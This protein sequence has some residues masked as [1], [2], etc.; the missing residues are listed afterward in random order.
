M[1]SFDPIRS[2]E[3]TVSRPRAPLAA[4]GAFLICG[5]MAGGCGD[6]SADADGSIAQADASIADADGSIAQADASTADAA[7]I[8]GSITDAT[9]ADAALPDATPADAA[10]PDAEVLVGCSECHGNATNAAP[11]RATDGETAT[12]AI[13]VGAHQS[14]VTDTSLHTAFSCQVCHQVPTEVSDP[15][16]IDEP[17]AEVV[18]GALATTGGVT[19]TWDR[20]TATCTDTYCHGNFPGGRRAAPKWTR[21]GEGQGQCGSCHFLPPLGHPG[22]DCWSCHPDTIDE[23]FHLSDKHV[24]GIVEAIGG[25]D[26]CHDAPPATGSHLVHYQATAD[27]ASYG[28]TGGTAALLPGGTGYAFDCGNCHP[29]DHGHHRNDVPNSGGGRAEI[30]LSPAGAPPGSLRARNPATA[31]YQPGGTLL[32]DSRGFA[33]T[34]GTCSDVYC[35]SAARVEVPGPVAV[36]GTDFAFPGYPLLIADYQP[37]HT[38]TRSRSY[39]TTPPWGGSLS[40]DGCHGF[41]PRTE[42]PEVVAGAGDSHSWIDENGDENLHGFVHGFPPVACAVC[43]HDT[44]TAS[45]SRT[46]DAN[47]WSVYGT[48]PI[49][50]YEFHVDG[51]ASVAFTPDPVAIKPPVPYD[52]DTASYDP[53]TRTC[54]D[55]GCH[56]GQTTVEWGLPY[57]SNVGIECNSCHQY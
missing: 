17:P 56:K 28:G 42:Y 50:G 10:P 47:G 38:V 20:D 15:D 24:D 55:V 46:R 2:P 36:P 19:P 49:V 14:H 8:D 9:P 12:T 29:L 52:L 23:S 4:L 3:P 25:C 11:P 31:S 21:V 16:H 5:G 13:A 51:A 35:H 18:W 30:D 33:Y 40:C 6:S 45:G 48:V 57:R 7:T 34:E 1:S 53:D 43:H 39:A 37:P 22:D 32:Y 41:P 54:S 27:E 44:V 26:G